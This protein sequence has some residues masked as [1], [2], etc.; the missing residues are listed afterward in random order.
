[1]L[2]QQ[3]QTHN[4][5]M[6]EAISY[7]VDLT[8]LYEMTLCYVPTELAQI[9]CAFTLLDCG[10]CQLVADASQHPGLR[11]AVF[12]SMFICFGIHSC[13]ALLASV[14]F[15]SM[16]SAYSL[17]LEAACLSFICMLQWLRLP[18]ALCGIN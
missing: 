14:L 17:Q 11:V 12:N 1:M 16:C 3:Q 15:I 10:H 4:I 18:D 2:R 13:C 9:R 8:T 7:L 6:S 5:I